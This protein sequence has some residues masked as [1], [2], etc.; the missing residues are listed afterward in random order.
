MCHQRETPGSHTMHG[1][2]AYEGLPKGWSAGG[3]LAEPCSIAKAIEL[4]GRTQ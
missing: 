3:L 4:Q 1:Y 2:S